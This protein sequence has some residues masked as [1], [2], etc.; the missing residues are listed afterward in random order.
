MQ[1]QI[2]I[3]GGGILGLSIAWG[4][5]RTGND[6]VVVDEGD[7]AFRASRGN[8]GLVWV[9]GKGYGMHEYAKWTRQ[10]ATL[11]P[12]L[13][14]E[15]EQTTGVNLEYS[16]KGGVDFCLSENEAEERVDLMNDIRTGLEGDYPF[17]YLDHS[18]L[19]K[20]IPEI[21]PTVTGATWTDMDGHVNPLYLLRAL[22]AG[23]IANGGKVINNRTVKHIEKRQSG[24]AINA[25]VTIESEKVVL[26]AGLGNSTLGPMVGM[27]VP[28][29]PNRGQ[30]MVCERVAPFMTYPSVQ[31]RQVGE[32]VVQIGD[33]KEDV[34]LNDGT[35][36]D[37]LAG[38]ARRAIKIY[39]LLAHL[40]AVRTWAALRVMTPD[41]FPIYQQSSTHPGAFVVTCHSGITLAAAHAL[42]LSQWIA[43]DGQLDSLNNLESFSG[44]RFSI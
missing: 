7:Q 28:V 35:S 17:E 36:T 29:E 41:G 25:G 8:F 43:S 38:I 40:R 30:I 21:G 26:C 5:A 18:R 14:S 33:S 1:T 13:V 44:N 9:Q 20:L 4:L 16:Q 11:W 32:G 10:S 34:G 2:T 22:Y 15:L 27:S 39:P 31:I 23:F 24:F 42:R 19:K 6:V 12:Q 3:I 37:V